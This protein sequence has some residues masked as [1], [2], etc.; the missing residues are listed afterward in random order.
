MGNFLKCPWALLL[1]IET[2]GRKVTLCIGFI[3][4]KSQGLM[5][6][7]HKS[8]IYKPE[9]VWGLVASMCTKM[10][11]IE[12][13][14][15]CIVPASP[16]FRLDRPSVPPTCGHGEYWE[17]G[18]FSHRSAPEKNAQPS[19]MWTTVMSDLYGIWLPDRTYY[20]LLSPTE[21]T[22]VDRGGIEGFWPRASALRT[23]LIGC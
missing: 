16:D 7:S 22:C 1:E 12:L 11:K 10:R 3:S 18:S 9:S 15:K 21:T 2:P 20:R 17:V 8:E 23:M 14:S 4:G 5:T 13:Q 6:L 19:Q